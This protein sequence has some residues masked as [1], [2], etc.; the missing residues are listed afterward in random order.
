MIV[1]SPWLVHCLL[2]FLLVART[3]LVLVVL[4]G[5]LRREW[6]NH[7]LATDMISWPMR[8]NS[9]NRD[10]SQ[11]LVLKL[12]L[13][14]LIFTLQFLISLLFLEFIVKLVRFV[15][16][17]LKWNF[18]FRSI[19][20]PNHPL[21]HSVNHSS[22]LFFSLTIISVPDRHQNNS[23]NMNN[24]GQDLP[25]GNTFQPG[26]VQP[27]AHHRFLDSQTLFWFERKANQLRVFVRLTDEPEQCMQYTSFRL[28]DLQTGCK[29]KVSVELL[30][31]GGVNG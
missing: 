20:S 9:C 2:T 31:G 10:L 21:I 3:M 17:V 26:W 28:I 11:P 12:N 8:C 15:T 7:G 27:R 24:P 13:R 23:R 22:R 6:T 19:K 14:F 1:T 4:I 16:H 25:F 5:N 29:E 18:N 30:K